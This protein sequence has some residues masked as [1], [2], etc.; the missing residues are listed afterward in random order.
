MRHIIGSLMLALALIAGVGCHSSSTKSGGCSCSHEGA[1]ACTCVHCK[2]GSAVC[3][4]P[5]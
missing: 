4:C 5:K 2:G 3:N 1:S